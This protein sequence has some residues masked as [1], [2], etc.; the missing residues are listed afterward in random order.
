MAHT[1]TPRFIEFGG[2]LINTEQIKWAGMRKLDD[3]TLHLQIEF[4]GS[5]WI[6]FNDEQTVEGLAAALNGAVY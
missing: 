1:P 4:I 5:G 2:R 6:L 3:G